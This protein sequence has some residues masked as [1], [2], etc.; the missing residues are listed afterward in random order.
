MLSI[1]RGLIFLDFCSRQNVQCFI[2]PSSKV[3]LELLILDTNLAQNI[4]LLSQNKEGVRPLACYVIHVMLQVQ[5]TPTVIREG[6]FTPKNLVRLWQKSFC[7]E[8]KSI[9]NP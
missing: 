3:N 8:E 5:S 6:H 7:L 4:G 9:K 1:L 2:D